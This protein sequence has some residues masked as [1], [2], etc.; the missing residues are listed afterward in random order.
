MKSIP[1]RVTDLQELRALQ[2][3]LSD[4]WTWHSADLVLCAIAEIERLRAAQDV[5]SGVSSGAITPKA[6]TTFAERV[7][8]DV[9]DLPDRTSPEDWP[10][11]MIVTGDELAGI[12]E[13]RA[14]E[15]LA[16]VGTDVS[17]APAAE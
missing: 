4:Q 14:Q 3:R 6:L 5:G 12:V 16:R 10:E 8:A 15:M 1:P 13:Q 7:C 2:R 9:A 11:A 17:K